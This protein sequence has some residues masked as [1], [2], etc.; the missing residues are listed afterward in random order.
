MTTFQ[1]AVESQT[2]AQKLAGGRLPAGEALRYAIQVAESLQ[3]LHDEGRVHGALSPA[4]IAISGRD[5]YL[6]PS[7][8][9]NGTA[10]YTAPE[11]SRGEAADTRSDIF[12]FGAILYEMLTGERAFVT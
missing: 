6:L 2:L 12:G 11:V 7:G 1:P 5:L 10:S 3:R 4:A 8:E 9:G